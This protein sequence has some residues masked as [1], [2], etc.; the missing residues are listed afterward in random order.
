[1]VHVIDDDSNYG[2]TLED[3][4]I[5]NVQTHDDDDDNVSITSLSLAQDGPSTYEDA[6]DLLEAEGMG[7]QE[8]DEL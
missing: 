4:I 1:M 3:L 8:I 5:C 7:M 2:H 6:I